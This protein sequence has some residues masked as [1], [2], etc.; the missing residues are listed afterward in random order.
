MSSKILL[1]DDEPYARAR[2]RELLGDIASQFPHEVIAE[3]GDGRAALEAVANLAPDI[4]LLDIQMPLMNGIEVASHLAARPLAPSIIF[5]TAFDEYAL[6]AFEVHALDYLV[7]PVRAPRLLE[8]LK[9]TQ[10]AAQSSQDAL[11][12]ATRQIAP[13]GRAHLSVH[14]RGKVSLIALDDVLYLKAEL[15]YVTIKTQH[16]EHIS[17]ESL[18][19]LEEEF[20]DRFIRVHRNALVARA[21]ITGFERVDSGP[22]DGGEP[23]WEVILRGTSER[24]PISRRQ[25]PA[26]RSVIRPGSGT[27]R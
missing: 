14:E 8:S 13:Q 21:A 25:W 20:A 22:D 15:K 5:V 1:V 9:R 11:R 26:V 23:H 2:L 10:L 19:G 27:T 16:A 3:A 17:E 24:L 4:V 12:S 18:I 7:K 6:R